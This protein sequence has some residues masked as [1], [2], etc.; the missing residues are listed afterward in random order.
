MWDREL[1]RPFKVG[2]GGMTM[3]CIATAGFC[4]MKRLGS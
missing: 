2:T 4:G 1:E 3:N